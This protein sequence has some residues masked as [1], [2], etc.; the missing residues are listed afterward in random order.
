MRNYS[1]FELR[2]NFYSK[3]MCS[4]SLLLVDWQLLRLMFNRCRKFRSLSFCSCLDIWIVPLTLAIKITSL[5]QTQLRAHMQTNICVY[6]RLGM[7]TCIAVNYFFYVV[8]LATQ[9]SKTILCGTQEF[10]QKYFSVK[11]KLYL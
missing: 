6:S 8:C 2:M 3:N 5:V 11:I 1:L 10:T 9:F 4:I 7:S